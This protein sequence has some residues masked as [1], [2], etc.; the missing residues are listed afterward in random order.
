MAGLDLAVVMLKGKEC[1]FL[2]HER[3]YPSSNVAA[4]HQQ[5]FQRAMDAM[6]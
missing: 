1:D 5:Q 6:I 4:W 3:A 2:Y